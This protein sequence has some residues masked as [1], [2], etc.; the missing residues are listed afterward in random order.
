MRPDVTGA[1]PL[2]VAFAE[3]STE[4]SIGFQ[5]GP[6]PL[7]RVWDYC[8]RWGLDDWALTYAIAALDRVYLNKEG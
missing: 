2:L 7:S 3:L 4:R 8:D 1:E 5:V 6:I